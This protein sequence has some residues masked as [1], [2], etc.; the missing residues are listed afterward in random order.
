MNKTIQTLF[1]VTAFGAAALLAQA[2]PAP[3]ILVVDLAKLFDSHYRTEEQAAK[4]RGDEQKAQEELD[5]MAKEG[6][7]LVAKYK[8]LDEQSRN[9]VATPEAKAKIQSDGQKVLEDIRRKQAEVQ[10]FQQDTR[11][12][13]QQRMKNFH[14]L[15]L[16]EISK[17]AVDIAK[18]RGATFLV[19]KSGQT[20]NG[21]PN[22][23]YSDPDYDIT[24]DVLKEINKDR[25]ATVTAPSPS[26]PAPTSSDSPNITLPGAKKP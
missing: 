25:P 18:R 8:D 26:T 16:E 2:Q 15:L 5:R 4:L 22:L 24:A 9:P 11:N 23:V 3:K 13:L 10:K 6:N 20:L 17:I 21:V 7:E 14:D 19:D 12:S 1:A